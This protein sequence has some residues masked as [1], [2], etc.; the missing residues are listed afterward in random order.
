M[1][2]AVD[3]AGRLFID[4]DPDMFRCL[5]QFM[6]AATMPPQIYIK[7]NKESLLEECLFFGLD[8]MTHRIKGK[9]SIYDLLPRDRQLSNEEHEKGQGGQEDG[10]HR[11]FLLDVF[12]EDASPLN[13]NDL[14]LP[15]LKPGSKE[16]PQV[17]CHNLAQ[18]EERFQK[19]SHGVFGLIKQIPGIVIAGGSIMST[20]TNRVTSDIDIFLVSTLEEAPVILERIYDAIKQVDE[21]V[22][23]KGMRTLVTRSK[24]AVLGSSCLEVGV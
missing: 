15:L 13:P 12:K 14:G 8:H 11:S 10:W 9:A 18:F 22:A 24:H 5:L 23:Q 21:N 20:L 17:T 2:H 4:R 19:L 6:R 16:K 3:H 1:E 7:T